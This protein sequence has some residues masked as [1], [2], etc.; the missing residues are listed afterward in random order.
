M[1]LG[2]LII[3]YRKENNM[4]QRQFAKKCGGVS[5]GYVSMLENNFNPATSKGIT[6]SLD[7]LICIAAGMDMSLADLLAKADDV[8]SDLGEVVAQDVIYEDESDREFCDMIM[9]ARPKEGILVKAP[10]LPEP[11]AEAMDIARRY[12]SLDMHG[13]EI[14]RAVLR[15]EDKRCE[16]TRAADAYLSELPTN[17][18]GQPVGIAYQDG[19]VEA[20]YAAKKEMQEMQEEKV[21]V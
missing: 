1:N 2:E 9:H 8:P 20:K 16:S 11:S 7:K 13:R 12:D 6:P 21:D 15:I 10:E 3:A 18:Y 5:N 17:E 4:S 14:I 19:T